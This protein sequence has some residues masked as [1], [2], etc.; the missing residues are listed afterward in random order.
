MEDKPK[1]AYFWHLKKIPK[2]GIF[3]FFRYI[4][5][6]IMFCFSNFMYIYIVLICHLKNFY[7]N[8]N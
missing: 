3:R 7:K 6:K 5:F 4:N 8:E 2:N 1:I